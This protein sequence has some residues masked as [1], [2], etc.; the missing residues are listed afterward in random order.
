MKAAIL[1][2]GKGTRIGALFPDLPKPMIPVCGKPV[3][4]WQVESLISQ[5]INNITLIVGYQS[6]VICNHFGSGKKLGA[7]I[8]YIIE[9]E[10]LGT[11]GALS[12]LPPEDT[13]ILFGDIFCDIDFSRFIAFH[14]KKQADVTLFVHPNSH[15][16][17]SD[18][19]VTDNQCKVLSWKSKKDKN[20]GDLRN[21]VNAGLYILSQKAL[22]TGK[23]VKYDL[24]HDLIIPQIA[25][26]KVYAYRSAEYV[27]DMG[28]PERLRAVERDIKSGMTESRSLRNKQ[29]AVF[30]DRDGTINEEDGFIGSPDQIK[31]IPNIAAAIRLLNASPYLAICITNQPVVARGDV[32][33]EELEAIHARLDTLLGKEGVYLDD[34][35]FC[36]HHTDKGFAGEVPELKFACDCRKPKPGL[37]L[38]AAKQYNIDLT[39]S[40]MIGDSSAD[41]SAG[42]VA[43][44]KTIG[45]KTGIALSDQKY[46]A[47]A[48]Y[49][50]DDLF[51]AT[52]LLI[53]GCLPYPESPRQ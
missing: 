22:P 47:K 45:V 30:I 5:G 28:T 33:F 11:G 10:P 52:Q 41:I 31:L 8:E 32:S 19:I 16:H 21:L 48:D 27:K 15:P 29:R 43:G 50:F 9:D 20:R 17:D 6:E 3:L 2:G 36:P 44:C 42:K 24:D 34:L 40:F 14:E 23:T 12:L 49:I 51:Y 39:R 25:D 7:K 1:A 38:E 37:L 18:V 4:Q 46:D 35:F 26:G 53:R 13:L